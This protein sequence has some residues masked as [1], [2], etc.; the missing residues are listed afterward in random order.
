MEDVFRMLDRQELMRLGLHRGDVEDLD[1]ESDRSHAGVISL[2][3]AGIAEA[4]KSTLS[5]LVAALDARES[6]TADHS[7]RVVRFTLAIAERLAVPEED[8]EQI[9][10]GALLHD[11]GKI[12]VSDN[13]LLKPGLLTPAEWGAMRRHPQIGH[14]I[15]RGIP[16]LAPAAEIVLCH[17]ERWDGGGYP[18]GLLRDEI[19][20]GARI[21][22]I[23][24]TFDAIT[25][26]RPYRPASTFSEARREIARC[27]GSQFDPICVSAFLG[28][29]ERELAELRNGA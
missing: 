24:D 17:Q 4:Y 27:G 8:L 1:D 13:I 28:L 16:F 20:L 23:A 18:R 9:A 12:G 22:A 10:R 21:F 5:A 15:L 11:I 26:D 7:Q 19:P 3:V 29:R 2:A 14:Q 6:E 25:S